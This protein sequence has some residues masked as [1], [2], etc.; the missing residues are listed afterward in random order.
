[1]GCCF[2]KTSV[3]SL[4]YRLIAPAIHDVSLENVFLTRLHKVF[5]MLAASIT[6]AK[7]VAAIGCAKT[8]ASHVAMATTRAFSNVWCTSRRMHDQTRLL[9]VLGCSDAVDTLSHYLS[10]PHLT[11]KQSPDVNNG[12]QLSHHMIVLPFRFTL[13]EY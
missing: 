3:K 7:V 13:R 11:L 1:M 6:R 12:W 10:C 2:G 4:V 5:P 8:C 9:C